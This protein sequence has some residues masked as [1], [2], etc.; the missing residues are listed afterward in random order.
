MANAAAKPVSTVELIGPAGRIVVNA[1]EAEDLL[2]KKG[3]RKPETKPEAGPEAKHE[4]RFG[5]GKR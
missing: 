5:K 2:K 1:S 4:A 3:Y